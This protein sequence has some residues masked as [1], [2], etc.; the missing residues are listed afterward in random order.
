LEHAERYDIVAFWSR[1]KHP[2]CQSE[3]GTGPAGFIAGVGRIIGA[4]TIAKRSSPATN[5]ENLTRCRRRLGRIIST[6]KMACRPSVRRTNSAAA[7]M[8][9][10]AFRRHHAAAAQAAAA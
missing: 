7:S 6:M 8:V 9:A 2:R 1:Q 5:M 3:N 4:D 10:G